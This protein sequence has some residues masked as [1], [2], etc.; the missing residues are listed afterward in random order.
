[1]GGFNPRPLGRTGLKVSPLGIGAGSSIG[2]SDLLYAFSRGINYFFYSSDLHH[3]SYRNCAGALKELCAAGSAVR[4]QVVLSTVTY[5][6]NP[7]KIIAVLLDQFSELG[8]DY[9]DIFHWGWVTERDDPASLIEVGRTMQDGGALASFFREKVMLME[10]VN[11]DL[12]RRGLVRW[13]G[14]SFHSRSLAREWMGQLDVVMLR[15]NLAHLGLERGIFPLLSGDK[16]RDPGLVVFNVAHEGSKLLSTPPPGYPP[17]LF[18]PTIPDC[19]RYALSN[20]YVDLVLAGIANRQELDAAL[21]ALEKGP[22]SPEEGQYL[23]EY[24]A[25]WASA[26]Q[27]PATANPL[28]NFLGISV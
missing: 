17:G 6:N 15:Y 28:M 20:Q 26:G 19:Y 21:A 12:V 18:V 7:D 25:A 9:I 2:N 8:V 23:R 3:F 10:E 13:V 16:T 4:D 5:I 14:A 1:M 22:L 11:R 24:G 27:N